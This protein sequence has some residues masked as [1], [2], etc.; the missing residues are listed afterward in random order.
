[1]YPDRYLQRSMALRHNH[2]EERGQSLDGSLRRLMLR[3]L[4]AQSIVQWC[5]CPSCIS[6]YHR[7]SSD[8]KVSSRHTC[9]RFID[10]ALACTTIEDTLNLTGFQ[11]EYRTPRWQGLNRDACPSSVTA[12]LGSLRAGRSERVFVSRDGSDLTSAVRQSPIRPSLSSASFNSSSPYPII[13]HG[14]S[15]VHSMSYVRHIGSRG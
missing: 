11:N 5:F 8:G 2:L 12:S 15:A 10:I 14:L 1:M 6:G 13:Y 3:V 7:F 4:G 9:H